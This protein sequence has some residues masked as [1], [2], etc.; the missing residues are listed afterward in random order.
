[1]NFYFY[2]AHKK[3]RKVLGYPDICTRYFYYNELNE[4]NWTWQQVYRLEGL[5]VRTLC[6]GHLTSGGILQAGLVLFLR[7][8]ILKS[9]SFLFRIIIVINVLD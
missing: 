8:Q 5:T 6:S 3:E 9:V 7:Q 2:D 1:M 4:G